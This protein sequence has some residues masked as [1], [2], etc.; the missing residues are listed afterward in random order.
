MVFLGGHDFNGDFG[1]TTDKG[2][3]F[4][5]SVFLREGDSVFRTYFTGGVASK[6]L[7]SVWSFLDLTPLGR[8][9]NWEDSPEGWP[10]TPRISGGA[11]TTSTTRSRVQRG[12]R[13]SGPA[14]S[15]LRWAYAT[16]ADPGASTRNP[17][18]AA[19]VAIFP[20]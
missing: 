6:T 17:Q 2:E 14:P 19:A 5:L 16:P 12:P 9:E 18:L 11:G 3:T 20:S 7:G 15:S 10:Q 1:R 4:G 13:S 8:Q